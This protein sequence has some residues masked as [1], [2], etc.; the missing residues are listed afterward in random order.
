MS[1][2]IVCSECADKQEEIYRLREEN[3]HLK[4]KLRYQE[5]KITEGYFGAQTPSSKRPFKAN[6]RNPKS[7]N[8][9]GGQKKH[10]GY[11]RAVFDEQEADSVERVESPNVCP[12]CGQK[13]QSR[14]VRKRAVIDVVPLKV[15]KI[16]YELE[17]KHCSHCKKSVIAKA[18]GVLPKALYGNCLLAHVATEHYLHG[19]PLGQLE[20][21]LG[22]G[23]GALV[24]GMHKVAGILKDVPEALIDSYRQAPVKHADETGWRNNGQ[25]GYGWLF[26]TPQ[27]SI[28]R[29]RKSRS[30]R[31]VTETFGEEPLPGVLV[32]DRYPGYNR[33]PCA[34]QYCYAHL[35]R[36]IRDL[37]KEFP[38]NGQVKTFVATA[39]PLLSEAMSLRSLPIDDEEFYRRAAET[40]T[41]II[42]AMQAE[43]NH[44]GIQNIQNIFR[45]NAHRLYHW[46]EDRTVPAENNL[47]E[48]QLRP[49]VI[50]RKISFGSHSDAGAKTRE[51]MMTVL[52]SLKNSFQ[53]DPFIQLK[54]CLDAYSQNQNKSPSQLLFPNMSN[55]A[56]LLPHRN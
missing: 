39:A 18:P 30:A 10:K 28:F 34:I 2:R 12:D 3:K 9:G 46:A 11:G 45:N 14:G 38:D 5:R 24:E 41:E 26:A 6:D 22:I 33:V 31:V 1:A 21:K 35:L 54:T 4:A 16:L 29:F 23:Y 8:K 44:A 7:K 50:A 36:T 15:E 17:Y 13:L 32:V 53:N 42:K 19:V 49:L 25:N 43:A 51:V 27:L 20:R 40:K 56:T 48:R 37:E 47:A 52:F 55:N